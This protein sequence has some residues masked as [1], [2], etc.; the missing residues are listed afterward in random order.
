MK[1]VAQP[2]GWA[3]TIYC[4]NEPGPKNVQEFALLDMYHSMMTMEL[5]NQFKQNVLAKGAKEDNIWGVNW[6]TPYPYEN[7]YDL[8]PQ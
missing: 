5:W 4:T 8:L 7:K 6:T 3:I 2:Y 1:R